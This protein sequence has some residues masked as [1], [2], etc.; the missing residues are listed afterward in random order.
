MKAGGINR[1]KCETAK[2]K[3]TDKQLCKQWSF[4]LVITQT[5]ATIMTVISNND[6]GQKEDKLRT[7]ASTKT[8]KDKL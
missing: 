5:I 2:M 8:K 3:T 1:R 6:K 7:H 4:T